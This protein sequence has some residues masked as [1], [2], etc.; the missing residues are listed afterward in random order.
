L[1][2]RRAISRPGKAGWH[3]LA[4][5][6]RLA[7]AESS[8]A[9]AAGAAIRFAAGRP[10]A[11]AWLALAQRRSALTAG[12]KEDAL[13]DLLR[14]N[15]AEKKLVFVQYRETLDHLAGLLSRHRIAFTRFEGSLSLT[16][17]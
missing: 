7:A 16:A 12:G 17:S 5:R 15:P 14:R 3:R 6:H 1:Q 11:P 13:L 4:L 10:D 8:P 9:V 2:Q